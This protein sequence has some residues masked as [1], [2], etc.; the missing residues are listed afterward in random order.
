Q[1]ENT[2]N[3]GGG[4]IENDLFLAGRATF[5]ADL[6]FEN[7]ETSPNPYRD[8]QVEYRVDPGTVGSDGEPCYETSVITIRVVKNGD[9]NFASSVPD[10]G[11]VFCYTDS[12]ETLEAVTTF[13][14]ITGLAGSPNSVTYS[15][16]GVT[17]GTA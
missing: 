13:G 14:P 7:S 8:I 6:A 15:G 1:G 9:F 12:P 4:A 16:F 2:F 10:A 5:D 3:D 11:S 17:N